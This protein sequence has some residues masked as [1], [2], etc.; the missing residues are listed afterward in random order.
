MSSKQ[1]EIKS[2]LEKVI[3]HKLD[4]FLVLGFNKDGL[5]LQAGDG[6][7]AG[8]ATVIAEFFEKFPEIEQMVSD[9]KK[10]KKG[11]L[12]DEVVKALFDALGGKQN[13]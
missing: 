3:N 9:A 4:G 2:A 12:P 13:E 1:T 6:E 5:E 11:K 8:I 7:I 10:L